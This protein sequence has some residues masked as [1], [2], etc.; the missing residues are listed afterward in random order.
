MITRQFDLFLN[1]GVAVAPIIN[2][3]QYDRN[4]K[5]VF[6]LYE[7]SGS[8]YT[9][10][11]G[12]IIGV[13]SDGHGIINTAEINSNG[14]VVVTETEQMTAA[15]GK[16]VFEL[17][18]ES[19]THGTANFVVQV[20]PK[21][22]DG[23][24]ISDSDY[25]YIEDALDEITETTAEVRSLL[26]DNIGDDGQLLTKRG[27]NSRWET[28]EALPDGGT[29]GQ[30]LTRT[31]GGTTADWQDIEAMPEGGTTGQVV[32]KTADG[33]GWSTKVG[34]VNGLYPDANSNVQVDVELTRNEW[35][36]LP[37]SK[38]TDDINY[39]IKD[40]TNI[41]QAGVISASG[42]TYS[43]TSSGLD[44][45]T[46]QDAI[47]ENASEIADVKSGLSNLNTV[48]NLGAV[49]VAGGA[50]TDFTLT[51]ADYPNVKAV[52]PFF[53]TYT[54]SAQASMIFTVARASSGWV[55]HLKN[56][57]TSTMSDSVGAI[58]FH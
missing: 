24:D 18:I 12:A 39:Y 21:P 44:A 10:T 48:I 6:T 29:D 41:P 8:L 32:T 17:M 40:G 50:S 4:E 34:A 42:V 27:E 47:D 56:S 49:S 19:G 35:E 26:P 45:T 31:G 14:Q 2:V 55:I 1:K 51:D 3:N 37:S 7:E 28:F 57:G 52:F 11:N 13:K 16:A 9:P 43:N 33:Y 38:Y 46:V 23:A 58:L 22:T 30:V 54:S 53:S 20:E 15:V 25:S 36:S 5:W